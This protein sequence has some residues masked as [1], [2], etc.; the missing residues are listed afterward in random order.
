MPEA[1]IVST[2]RSPIGRAFKGSLKDVRPDDLATAVGAGEDEVV[3]A[4]L[5]RLAAEVVRRR[6]VKLDVRAHRAVVDEYTA[7]EG[8]QVGMRRAGERMRHAK[9][10]RKKRALTRSAWGSRFSRGLTWP[11]FAGN[12]HEEQLL[13][14]PL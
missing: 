11:Q 7:G 8:A 14:C 2:A 13:Y 6:I 3:V 9:H 10:Q 5:E 4:A 1:V 12:R